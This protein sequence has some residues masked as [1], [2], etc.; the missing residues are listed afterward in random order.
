MSKSQF[1]RR[2]V[3]FVMIFVAMFIGLAGRV[4][5]TVILPNLPAN[6]EYQLIFAT[7]GEINSTS[8]TI[9][10]YNAFVSANAAPLT[11]ILPAGVTWNAVVSTGA[12]PNDAADNAPSFANI[13][14]YNTQ[15]IE[16]SPGGLY[17]GTGL[18]SAID[19]DQ[20]GTLVAQSAG[21]NLIWTG[22]T[23][24]GAVSANPLGA[25]SPEYGMANAT[26][27]NWITG[28]NL[29][30]SIRWPVYALSTPITVVPEPTTLSLLGAAMLALGRFLFTR[31]RMKTP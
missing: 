1:S 26:S 2:V 7:S 5:A 11:A 10:T 4:S 29:S 15:G 6:S 14:I 20:N 25:S 17:S 30:N 24:L 12:S 22:A 3:L 28:N 27:S 19:Y 23:A 18:L 13:P 21:T 16:V 31:R 8:G 9:G